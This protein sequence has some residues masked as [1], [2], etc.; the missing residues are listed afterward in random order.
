M[1]LLLC[2][3]YEDPFCLL[4]ASNELKKKKTTQLFQ[5]VSVFQNI[6]SGLV[7]LETLNFGSGNQKN[8]NLS[9][10]QYLQ[11]CCYAIPSKHN[12]GTI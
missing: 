11:F 1:N 12:S 8:D 9:S 10:V 5:S 3:Q 4:F 2:C 7:F 6:Q